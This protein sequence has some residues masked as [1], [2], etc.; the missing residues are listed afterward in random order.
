MEVKKSAE[1]D[2]PLLKRKDVTF[3][4]DHPSAGTPKLFEVRKAL[5]SMYEVSDDLV[6]VLNLTTLTGT[7]R[8]VGEAEVYEQ[9]ETTHLVLP[10]HIQLRNLQ[11]RGRGDEKKATKEQT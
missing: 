1:K 5:A 6:Y 9:A 11:G 10:K 3:F 7:H 8:T 2:N 4:I